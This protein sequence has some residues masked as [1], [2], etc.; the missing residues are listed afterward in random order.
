MNILT[1]PDK[2]LTKKCKEV[3]NF[4]ERLGNLLDEMGV[5]LKEN[6]ALGLAS[7]Q[8]GFLEQVFII[9]L[10]NQYVLEVI[11]P[12]I[13]EEIGEQY[14]P[15]GCLSFP[16]IFTNIKRAQQIQVKWK[17]RNGEE[18]EGVF[19]DI[20]AREFL[21]E[22]FHLQGKTILDFVNRSE[23]KRILKELNK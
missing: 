14:G 3:I 20:E 23:R 17:N 1:W 2:N 12:V 10:N 8:L 15:E 4:D 5:I 9:K 16:D 7:S 6:N 11:N 21:H 18:K 13:L 19:A 22:F